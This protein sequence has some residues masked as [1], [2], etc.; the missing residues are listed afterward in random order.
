ME[1]FFLVSFSKVAFNALQVLKH[2]C[3]LTSDSIDHDD[4]VAI[5]TDAFRTL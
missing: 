3:Y 2:Y 1:Y 5:V 4:V